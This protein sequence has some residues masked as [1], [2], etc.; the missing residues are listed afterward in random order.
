MYS[1]TKNISVHPEKIQRKV[2]FTIIPVAG[3]MAQG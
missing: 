3:E 2:V 1:Y